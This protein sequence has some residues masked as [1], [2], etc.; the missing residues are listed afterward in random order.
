MSEYT[1]IVLK[2]KKGEPAPRFSM[3]DEIKGCKIA[4]LA[5]GD[6]SADVERLEQKIDA[7]SA[8]CDGLMNPI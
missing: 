7:L 3:Q 6:L 8:E 4:V 2:H 5:K 1:T